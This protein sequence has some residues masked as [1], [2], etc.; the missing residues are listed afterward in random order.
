MQATFEEVYE[1]LE[2][3]FPESEIRTLAGQRKLL[4]RPGYR[5][6]MKQGEDGGLLAVMAVWEFDNLRFVEHIAVHPRARGLGLGGEMMRE[7]QHSAGRVPVI[8][9]VE[10]PDTTEFAGRRI[11][12]YERLGFF[13]NRYP[14]K[15]PPLREGQP[16]LPLLLMSYPDPL[17]PEEFRQ[18]AS[19]LYTRVYEK[20]PA[21]EAELFT[22]S[23]EQAGAG[24]RGRPTT[25]SSD[26]GGPAGIGG[27]ERLDERGGHE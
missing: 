9:E 22:D 20:W 21:G 14:Y 25:S 27:R 16:D 10:P 15:Q 11:G 1:L 19:T 8:L 13:L 12:F 17:T 5:L 7:Y 2:R 24:D 6:L 3:S 4:E 23:G 26:P 18:C